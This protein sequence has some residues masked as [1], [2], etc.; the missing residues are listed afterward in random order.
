MQ[1]EVAR[2]ASMPDHFFIALTI[3]RERAFFVCN[4]PQALKHP[5]AADLKIESAKMF[6]Q[7]YKRHSKAHPHAMP[8]ELF[9]FGVS[10]A[11][12]RKT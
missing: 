12:L 7:L 5:F 6:S 4:Y 2:H 10:E 3:A 8:L 9:P 11:S 1:K